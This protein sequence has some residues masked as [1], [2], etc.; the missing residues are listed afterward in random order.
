MI[1]PSVPM[2]LTEKNL[3]PIRRVYSREFT[4]SNR[5]GLKHCFTALYVDHYHPRPVNLGEPGPA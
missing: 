4:T 5:S 3:H 2:G 1:F